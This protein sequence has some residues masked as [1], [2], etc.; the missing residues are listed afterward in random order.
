M[1]T[2]KKQHTKAC[3]VGDGCPLCEIAAL[4]DALAEA[5]EAITGK[6]PTGCRGVRLTDGD[7]LWSGCECI[8]LDC[9]CPQH[10]FLSEAGTLKVIAAI[11]AALEKP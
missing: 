8:G 7:L 11:D 2:H 10:E 1:S 5:R 3:L 6:C 9:D 4:R